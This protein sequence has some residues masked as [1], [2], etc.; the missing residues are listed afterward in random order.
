MS[1]TA[2]KDS[3]T[4]KSGPLLQDVFR[5]EGGEQWEVTIFKIVPDN[6]V[7]IQRH[8]MRAC[9]GSDPLN[10]IVTSGG[11]GF[12]PR[13]NTPEVVPF[14]STRNKKGLTGVGSNATNSSTCDW[15]S[16]RGS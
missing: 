2:A 8:I 16:V 1:D 3:S 11:T 6:V 14:L 13:D 7:E 10:L 12:A 5:Q 15:S 9:D 4:D